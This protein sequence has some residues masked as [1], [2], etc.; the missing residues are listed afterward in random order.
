MGWGANAG[1]LDSTRS[2]KILPKLEG[3]LQNTDIRN[4]MASP[5][6]LDGF[7]TALGSTAGRLNVT[8]NWGVTAG[9]RTP[10]GASFGIATAKGWT[11]SNV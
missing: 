8:G 3:L 4:A 1:F 5:T 11:F 9:G 10:G 7:F 2:L 6:E